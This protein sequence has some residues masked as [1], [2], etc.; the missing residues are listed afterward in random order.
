MFEYYGKIHVCGPGVG[1]D[2]PLVSELLIFSPT[3]HFPQDIS[4]E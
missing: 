3:A 4:F 2:V 1:A